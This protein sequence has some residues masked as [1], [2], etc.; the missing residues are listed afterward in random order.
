MKYKK[1]VNGN[2]ATRKIDRDEVVLRHLGLV[3]SIAYR[4]HESLPPHV[5][6]DDLIHAGVL[7]LIDAAQK[8]DAKKQVVFST[9]AKH[10]VRGAIIDSLR[11]LDWT[12][13]KIRE[14]QRKAEGAKQALWVTL[15]RAPTDEE[16]AAEIGVEIDQY[17]K[18][19]EGWGRST[20]SASSRPEEQEPAPPLEHEGSPS[21]RP[22]R[23]FACEEMTD[24]LEEA[25]GALPERYQEVVACYYSKQMTM[26]EIGVHMGINESRVSQIH[27]RALELMHHSLQ[28]N[29]IRSAADFIGF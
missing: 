9:Y 15:E 10:R 26:R 21:A 17:R 27:K 14:F 28:E 2:R 8:F 29:G 25:A 24:A 1:A 18:M 11:R 20:L 4:I 22:D 5:E 7:G 12:P 6:V 16:V 23:M 19:A 13:R 3:K